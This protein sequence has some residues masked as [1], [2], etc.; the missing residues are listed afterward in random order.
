M[1]EQ[2]V[3]GVASGGFEARFDGIGGRVIGGEE[4]DGALLGG[5]AVRKGGAAGDAGRQGE[6]QE[7]EATSGS[8]VEQG[9]VAKGD[10]TGPQPGEGLAGDVRE[11]EDSGLEG[12]RGASRLGGCAWEGRGGV[13][14]V[15]G[16]FEFV[17]EVVVDG[18]EG[19]GGGPF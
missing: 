18:F 6:G 1:E 10:A 14:V 15:G 5:C 7:G 17:Q 19:H 9:E 11:Q 2:D 8:S 3:G 13:G 4:D 12:S 16:A